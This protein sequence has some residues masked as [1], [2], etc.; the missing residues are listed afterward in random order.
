LYTPASLLSVVETTPVSTFV[1][2]T[3]TPGM[4]ALD[5]SSIV[6]L[7]VP[8]VDWPK[9]DAQNATTNKAAAENRVVL[10]ATSHLFFCRIWD[11]VYASH[12]RSG[13]GLR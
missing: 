7:I 12:G 1:A 11:A 4:S 3:V 9:P 5:A 6:P 2:V 10:L 8:Y 13:Q